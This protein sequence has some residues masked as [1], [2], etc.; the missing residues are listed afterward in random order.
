MNTAILLSAAMF[1]GVFQCSDAV[2]SKARDFI[3]NE[4]QFHLGFLPTEQSNP[5]TATLEEDFKRS[6]LAGVQCLQRGD[7]QIPITMR[8]VFAGEK[9]EK[10]VCSMVET[11]KVPKGRIIFSGCGATGRLSILLESMWRDFFHRRASELT[12]EERKLADRSASIMT[13]GDFALIKSVESFEDSMAGGERQAA[14]LNVGE[15]DTFVA[16]TEGGETSSVL[17]TLRYA[18]AKGA[19]CFLVFNNPAYLLKARLDRCREAI[20]NPKVTVLD[21]YCGSMSLAGSTRMQATSS[22]QLLA[23]CAM[24]AA[25]CRVLPRFKKETADDYTVAF[26]KLLSSLESPASRSNIADA[27]DFECS[28]YAKKGRVTYFA[29]DCMLDLFTDTTERSPTFMLPPFRST[30]ETALAQSW[31]FVKNP[32][33]GT[34]ACWD[35]LFHRDVRCLEWS[36]GDYLAPGMPKLKNGELPKIGR[37]FLMKY[38]IGNEDISERYAGCESA[39]VIVRAGKPDA[40]FEAAARKQATK[41]G[42]VRLFTVAPSQPSPLE[43]W[44]HLAVKLTFNNLSTGT[45]V[46]MGRVSGNW[47][48]WVAI[49]NKKLIDRGI[50]LISELGRIPYEEAAQRLFAAEEWIES[51]DW[52]GKETPCAVQI[53][54]QRLGKDGGK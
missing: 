6:T 52:T 45:M 51:Q 13:G 3:D 5:I 17:G 50:R 12:T 35:A 33:Y 22:E 44:K 46:K 53:A 16:I 1:A 38:P 43:V 49:S 42:S 8:H 30:D 15:G 26:E 25:L 48:S 2:E 7:R 28:L 9:F 4:K 19:K 39:A 37:R 18:A 21:I 23:S 36:H 29:D 47:M 31:A 32:L 11:L 40:A 27:I 24:E 34:E 41:F 54:L 20:D 10:L 14:A